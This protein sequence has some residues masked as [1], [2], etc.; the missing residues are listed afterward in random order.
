MAFWI[1]FNLYYDP[2]GYIRHYI[3]VDIIGR[4]NTSDVLTILIILYIL[5]LDRNNYFK[6]N[7]SMKELI[8]LFII[9]RLY[10]IFIYGMLIPLMNDYLD[11]STFFIKNRSIFRQVVILIGFYRFFQQGAISF[12]RVVLITGFVCLGLFLVTLITNI[13]LSPVNSISR[14]NA[15]GGPIRFYMAG[16]GLFHVTY[17]WAVIFLFIKGY[18]KNWK[19]PN[20]NLL[21]ITGC[22][23]IL[24]L[25]LTLTRRVYLEIIFKPFIIAFIMARLF[26]TSWVTIIRRIFA[27]VIVIICVLLILFPSSFGNSTDLIKDIYYLVT[28]GS[29]TRGEV[30]YRVSGGGGL[31]EAKDFISEN[32]ILG[33][34]YIPLTYDEIQEIKYSERDEF[35]V[36]ADASAE[37]WFWGSLFRFGLLGFFLWLPILILFIK[38]SINAYRILRINPKYYFEKYPVEGMM[39]IGTFIYLIEMFTTN[40]YAFGVDFGNNIFIQLM[41]LITIRENYKKDIL[42][43][44]N[45]Q[46][47]NSKLD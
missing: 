32:L 18:I 11:L 2:G 21:L 14:Y 15:Q 20:S 35:I 1:L 26:R 25:L 22:M 8:T 47:I 9:F 7:N 3:G 40:I 24:V 41:I 10:Y 39:I 23:M 43:L 46:N 42:L 31:N 13:P 34:G 5:F 44:I 4:V 38:I 12:Y 37:V 16:Y 29:D 33:S 45:K 19:F 36:G 27:P 17:A 28:T 6:L 30:D